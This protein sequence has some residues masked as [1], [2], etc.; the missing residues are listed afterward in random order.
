MYI[1]SNARQAKS[2]ST[3]LLTLVSLLV[4]GVVWLTSR[5]LKG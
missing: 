4:V 1:T 3:L 5:L 2:E